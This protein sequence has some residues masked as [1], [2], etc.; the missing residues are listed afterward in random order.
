[1]KAHF[2]E[3]LSPGTF[4][5]ESTIRPIDSWDIEAAV[6]L[7]ADV[8]ERHSARPY[9]FRFLT[10]ERGDN[11]LDSKVTESSGVYYLGG[12]I[13][14]IDDVRKRADPKEEILLANMECNGIDRIVINENSW[15]WTQPLGERDTVLDVALPEVPDHA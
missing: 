14:T 2:V 5:A 7:A 10:R 8:V 4:V 15:R 6:T 3:F 11:E 13:D 12:R 9:G 1:M